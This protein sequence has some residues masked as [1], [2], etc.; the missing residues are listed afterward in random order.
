MWKY[1]IMTFIS[2]NSFLEATVID[3]VY[4]ARFKILMRFYRSKLS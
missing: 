2:K 4:T 3:I 1:C